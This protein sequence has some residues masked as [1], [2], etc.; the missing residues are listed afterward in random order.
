MTKNRVAGALTS[1]RKSP[2]QKKYVVRPKS[3]C[4]KLMT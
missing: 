2:M 4:Q 1:N 3:A